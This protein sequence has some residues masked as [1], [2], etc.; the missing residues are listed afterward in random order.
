MY[1]L[2]GI[3]CGII[4]SM[5]VAIILAI[6]ILTFGTLKMLY[7]GD[8]PYLFL[9]LDRYPQDIAKYKIVILKVD[10]DITQK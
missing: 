2:I 9:D 1:I 10:K 8:E 4:S 3:L 5:I 7:D 6:K